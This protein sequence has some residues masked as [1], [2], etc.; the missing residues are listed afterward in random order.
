MAYENFVHFNP[1]AKVGHYTWVPRTDA[2]PRR[3]D[4]IAIRNVSGGGGQ[5]V[6]STNSARPGERRP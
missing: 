1:V 2:G 3:T 5:Y 4:T 6:F